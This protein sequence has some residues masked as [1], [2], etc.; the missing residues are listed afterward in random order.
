[1]AERN[2]AAV[3]DI[4][5]EGPRPGRWQ[6]PI[7]LIVTAA[8]VSTAVFFART[9]QGA[10]RLQTVLVNWFAAPPSLTR[11]A[12][13]DNDTQ[14]LGATVQQLATDR[15]SFRVRIEAL[16]RNEVTGSVRPG[17]TS[18]A[19]AAKTMPWPL[20]PN[21]IELSGASD[22]GAIRAGA[23]APATG[24]TEQRAERVASTFAAS[25]AEGAAAE[26]AVSRTE[27]GIDIGGGATVEGLRALWS[28]AKA[29]HGPL[30]EGLRPLVAV[31]ERGS[32]MQL[33]LVVGPL[34][35][36]GAA[37]RLCGALSAA[38][39]FCQPALFDGQRLAL[40]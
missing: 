25:P 12:R 14:R 32:A 4:E 5:D 38:G 7:W 29:R 8:T 10:Q 28:A 17:T 39:V 26:S 18:A 6:L 34:T 33:R 11:V 24:T 22:G 21:A 2:P 35:N 3:V 27:F 20:V 37:A 31:N 13:A 19:A 40:R 23:A 16:E 1:M 15:D 30:L 9:E 36:A